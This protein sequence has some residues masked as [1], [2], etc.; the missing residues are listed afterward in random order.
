MPPSVSVWASSSRAS[1]VSSPPKSIST[2]PLRVIFASYPIWANCAC[3]Y[4]AA[5]SVYPDGLSIPSSRTVFSSAS[6]AY[7]SC[8]IALL[9]GLRP[10]PHQR[11]CLWTLQ[12]ADE[13][14]RSPPLDPF[15]AIELVTTAYNFRVFIREPYASFS[16][17]S[18][19]TMRIS[20]PPN[21]LPS[22]I[23]RIIP[24]HCKICQNDRFGI[25]IAK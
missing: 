20:L 22:I 11:R 12:G 4:F 25:A 17:Q 18:T 8:I 1:C 19:S 9:P 15:R 10:R 3:T 24:M 2:P 7:F 21:T 13:K 14:G 6:C 23:T 16:C 5:F